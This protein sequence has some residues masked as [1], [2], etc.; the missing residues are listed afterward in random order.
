M[1]KSNPNSKTRIP[2]PKSWR[3]GTAT[4]PGVGIIE[5]FE[6]FA[7]L[8]EQKNKIL[9]KN[10]TPQLVDLQHIKSKDSSTSIGVA[11]A[12]KHIGF[13]V[14]RI[15][16][17]YGF[18]QSEI[19]GLHA[20]KKLQ[21]M[22]IPLSGSFEIN[23]LG[24]GNRYSFKMNNPNQGLRL[25]PGYWRILKNFSKD[26]IC[27]VLASEEYQ[28]EDYIRDFSEFLNFE[29]ESMTI[30]QVPFV[31][32][33]RYYDDLRTELDSAYRQVMESGHY[34]MGSNLTKFENEFAS[35]CGTK[36]AI[37]VANG[38]EAIELTLKAW[39][40]KQGDE[41]IVASHGFIATALAVS[42]LGANPVLV[43]VKA[44]TY[45]IDPSK[46]E[47]AINSKTKAI[48][49]THLYGQTAD[50]QPI[51]ELAAKYN[52]KVLEDSAQAH[53]AMYQGKRAGS[54]GHA[55]SFS[56]YPTKNLGAFGDGGMITTNDTW[57]A[58]K[59]KKLRNYGSEIKY[60][61]DIQGTNSRLDE[62]QAAFLRI[63]LTKL[64]EWNARRNKLAQI[65]FEELNNI[66]DLVLPN[67]PAAMMPVYHVFAVRVL[68]NRRADLIQVLSENN[69]GHNI[70][71]PKPFYL[72]EAYK[73][74]GYKEGDFTLTESLASSLLSLPL[75]PYHSE[76][77]IRYVCKIIKDFFT[78][79]S[80]KSI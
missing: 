60:Q 18:E 75:D 78:S 8:A 29:K 65:Y 27:M 63:K 67:N 44:D 48:A 58:N 24:H 69:I 4:K 16:Y 72:Q 20:H 9:S 56:F 33:A 79:E 80:K 28:E 10:K 43:E 50:M 15:Y 64:D 5:Y 54:L 37:G 26:A 3:K 34:I 36:H 51:M 30:S 40:I 61:H 49:L 21:Q 42:K 52:L 12:S 22:I 53:G 17:I 68:N 1:G 38:L 73:D 41:V 6:I 46:I 2:I 76:E 19:R 45:N 66:S 25:P 14:R 31:D 35:Y 7:K 23:L 32:F 11:E 57:L 77:E 74:L 71:Y 47:A 70:H 55:A 59:L 39:D 62:M 13:D